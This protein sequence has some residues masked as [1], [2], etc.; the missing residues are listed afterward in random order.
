MVDFEAKHRPRIEALLDPG[1]ELRGICA[2]NH[3]QS[4]FKGRLVALGVTDRRLLLQPLD[5]R[6][7]PA[8]AAESILPEQVASAKAG[9]AGGGWPTPGA[10]IADHSAVSVKLRTTDG[11]KLKLMM[12]HGEGVFG[13]LGGGESQREGVSALGEWF[14]GLEA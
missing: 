1:E 13:G 4:A 9:G 6:G 11:R 12:M 7:D 5:R 8:G 10:A 14:A 3:R 2:V